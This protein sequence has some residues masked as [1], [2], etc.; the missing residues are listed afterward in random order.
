M[1]SNELLGVVQELFTVVWA[2]S[3]ST[4][5][6]HRRENAAFVFHRQVNFIS[7]R[8]GSGK[9]A[10]LAALQI[11]LGAKANLTHRAKKMADFIRYVVVCASWEPKG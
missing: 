9:S 2:T 1:F 5:R 3:P 6:S 8:N 10:I 11:C 7:G 4:M